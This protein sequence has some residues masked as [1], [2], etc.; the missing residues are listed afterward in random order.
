M[1]YKNAT[2]C[3]TGVERSC[4]PQ[5]VH[6]LYSSFNFTWLIAVWEQTVPL[7]KNWSAYICVCHIKCSC[8]III[9]MSVSSRKQNKHKLSLKWSQTVKHIETLWLLIKRL[10]HLSTYM[11]FFVQ[12]FIFLDIYGAKL[13]FR[14]KVHLLRD[15]NH[16]FLSSVQWEI[17]TRNQPLRKRRLQ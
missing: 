6:E 7:N 5:I 13:N 9:L 11:Y 12:L 17:Q 16:E 8:F 14:Y 3:L 15:P 10:W 4:V 1:L 2:E